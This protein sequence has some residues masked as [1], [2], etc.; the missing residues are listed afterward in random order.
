MTATTQQVINNHQQKESAPPTGEMTIN[1]EAFDFIVNS[2]LLRRRQAM[3]PGATQYEG[4][5]DINQAAGY[6]TELRFEHYYSKYKRQNIA[7]RIVNAPATH[8][9]RR[10]PIISDA[11]QNEV[12]QFMK[13]WAELTDVEV[14]PDGE[15]EDRPSLWH[16][17]TTADK[18]AGIG[19]FGAMLLGLRDQKDNLKHPVEKG[20]AVGSKGLL[21]V[22][23]L[24]EGHIKDI[25]LEKD[26]T[27]PRY[28]RPLH[29]E[30]ELESGS[31]IV[32]WHRV[33]HISDSGG[34]YGTPR[35]EAVFD[36]LDDL[37]KVTAGSGEAAFQLMKQK[38]ITSTKDGYALD[39]ANDSIKEKA[40]EFLHQLTP[41]LEL[42]GMDVHIQ[43]GQIVD[44]SP[45]IR[46]YIALISGTIS[47]PQRILLGSERGELASGQDSDNWNEFIE[48]R[49]TSFA[50]PIILRPLINR[51]V[52]AGVLPMPKKKRYKVT[53]PELKK[54]KTSEIAKTNRTRA[55]IIKDLGRVDDVTP[56]EARQLALLPA[57]APVTDDEDNT[58]KEPV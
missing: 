46:I 16:H 47:Y 38:I 54:P 37:L 35:M 2:L 32:H 24:N 41:F 50:E 18:F 58:V 57:K 23:P 6:K 34:L 53:W 52:Y 33:V 14:V 28:G 56:E 43:G 45:I 42:E 9:W 29:Y 20:K 31:E 11:K 21:Y 49:Q 36:L 39:E 30:I 10:P 3:N 12:T 22:T 13:A 8:T 17:L 7:S 1:K 51:L 15:P 44:P 5:R 19:R 55:L 25:K 40:L 4:D 26:S 48:G 27:S